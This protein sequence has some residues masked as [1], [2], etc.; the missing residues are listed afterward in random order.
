[1]DIKNPD[2]NQ[3]SNRVRFPAFKT[4]PLLAAAFIIDCLFGAVVYLDMKHYLDTIT[5][6]DWSRF[7]NY[8]LGAVN[9]L[10]S[11]LRSWNLVPFIALGSIA[12]LLTWIS[13]YSSLKEKWKKNN[14]KRD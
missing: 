9:Q 6:F 10:F 12:L 14:E 11:S 4:R 8:F 2:A 13:A 3:N 7:W 5:P 1:M